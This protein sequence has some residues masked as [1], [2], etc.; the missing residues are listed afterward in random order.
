VVIVD[1]LEF[2]VTLELAVIVVYQV[3]QEYR[4]T[5]VIVVLVDTQAYQVTVA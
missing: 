4:D 2:Q 5:L 3:T 1:I